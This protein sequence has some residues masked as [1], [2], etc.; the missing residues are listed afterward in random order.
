MVV[1]YVDDSK[2]DAFFFARAL[3]KVSPALEWRHVFDTQEA[4]CYLRGEGV[5]SD[6][7]KYPFPGIVISDA[8]MPDGTGVELLR[9][10]RGQGEW[11]EIRFCLFTELEENT[12]REL[13]KEMAASVCLFRK[14]SHPA[15]WPQVIH[16]MLQW[17]SSRD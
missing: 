1:L 6:R 16:E 17:N 5:F 3:K 12:Q 15:E 10:I 7:G 4:K 2:D 11:K 13:G 14:P 9:W 8:K